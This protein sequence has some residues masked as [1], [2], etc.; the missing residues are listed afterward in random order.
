MKR[1]LIIPFFYVAMFLI[2]ASV[3]VVV[4]NLNNASGFGLFLLI[5]GFIGC[6]L[7]AM[8]LGVNCFDIT[9]NENF[10]YY[11]LHK[12]KVKIKYGICLYDIDE[13]GTL[14]DKDRNA[15]DQK[16]T[17]FLPNISFKFKK[18]SKMKKS[19]IVSCSVAIFLFLMALKP[20][21]DC[22]DLYNRSVMFRNNYA[23]KII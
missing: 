12:N 2:V 16:H 4:S 22:T 9:D 20:F 3:I 13:H 8:F 21:S 1:I 5:A 15:I 10:N 14:Y 19:L 17:I 11:V 7:F 23:Q 6:A 18:I